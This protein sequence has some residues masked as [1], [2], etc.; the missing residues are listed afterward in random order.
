MTDLSRRAFILGAPLALAGC[1]G[2][3]PPMAGL[4]GFLGDG[5]DYQ[6]IYAAIDDGRFT[7][8][9]IDLS[10]VNPRF[11]RTRVTD[12]TGEAPGTIVV[13]PDAHFLYHVAD[14][15]TAMRYGVGVG[16]EGFGWHGTANIRRKAD[17][18]TWTPPSEMMLRDP[19]SAL[20]AGGMP[21]GPG[22]PLGAR[23]MY[24]YQGGRDT[25]YRIHGTIEPASIGKSMSSGCIRLLNQD[26]IHLYN[27]TPVGTR[28]VVLPS[29]GGGFLD[30]VM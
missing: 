26:I 17:W 30:G 27:H 13:D 6:E 8:P 24:L 21:G 19:Q 5:S 15:G 7:V 11:Y 29:S 3:P 28:V 23:A 22:N 1:A 10:K 4:G 25:M 18:P 12:P 20:Y 14:D 16:R 2:L 9:A